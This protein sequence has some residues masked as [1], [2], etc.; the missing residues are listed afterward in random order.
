MSERA[1]LHPGE[2]TAPRPFRLLAVTGRFQP[3]H[4]QHLELVRLALDRSDQV[5]I[6]VTNPDPHDRR[7]HPAS[8]HRHLESAN[9]YTYAERDRAIAAALQ[10]D[11]VPRS[12]FR[13]LPFPLDDPDRWP[14][15]VPPGTPQLVRV[16]SAWER[17]KVRRFD[18][19]GYPAI[20]LEGDP[21]NRVSGTEIRCRIA[22]GESWSEWVPPGAREEVARCRT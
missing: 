6:G 21:A 14:A 3:F 16:Y 5:L 17:E 2:G 11:G 18:A 19:A 9:P 4:V 1:V 12:R 15:L 8:A 20:V 10:A 7:A 13:I 22:A